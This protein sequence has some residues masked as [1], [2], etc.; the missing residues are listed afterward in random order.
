MA[1]PKQTESENLRE[2]LVDEPPQELS[3]LKLV[4]LSLPAVCPYLSV[5]QVAL[6]VSASG[7]LAFNMQ[8]FAFASLQ[9]SVCSLPCDLESLIREG[10][11]I[12]F[13]VELFYLL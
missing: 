10:K 4:H 1:G 12:D 8:C 3:G 7:Q 13:H 5:F 11:V 6:A 2:L 9:S